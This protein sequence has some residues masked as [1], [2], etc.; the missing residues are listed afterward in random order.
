MSKSPFTCSACALSVMLAGWAEPLDPGSGWGL[1]SS[2]PWHCLVSPHRSGCWAAD[3]QLLGMEHTAWNVGAGITGEADPRSQIP[4]DFGPM[5]PVAA[6]QAVRHLEKHERCFIP[7]QWL[8][9]TWALPQIPLVLQRG[10]ILQAAF[11]RNYVSLLNENSVSSP[12]PA[13]IAWAAQGLEL[14]V[15]PMSP[16]HPFL[17]TAASHSLFSSPPACCLLL[18]CYLTPK[19][20]E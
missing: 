19:E 15:P 10:K 5:S 4:I 18:S 11:C 3:A 6:P 14:R 17:P 7:A 16:I 12:V 20:T 13:H 1:T 8:A 9:N 2:V